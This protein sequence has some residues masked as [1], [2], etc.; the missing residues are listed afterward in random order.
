MNIQTLLEIL[1]LKMRDKPD[2]HVLSICEWEGMHANGVFQI[3]L[4]DWRHYYKQL[5]KDL[6]K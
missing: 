3:T 5:K 1:L 4:G 6:A 2:S